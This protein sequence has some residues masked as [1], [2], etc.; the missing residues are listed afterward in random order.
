MENRKQLKWGGWSGTLA[1]D[2]SLSGF[3][4]EHIFGIAWIALTLLSLAVR[5]RGFP[6]ESSDYQ[7]FLLPWFQELKKSGGFAALGR[8]VGNYN[9][10]YLTI[11]AALTYLPVPPLFSIKAVSILFDYVGA[12]AGA[13]IVYSL[14]SNKKKGEL[15]AAAAWLCILFHP[16]VFINSAFWG[17]C[18]FIYV[19]FLLLCIKELIR[20]SYVPA[21]VW[22]SFALAFKLQAVFFLPVLLIL[23]F[24]NRSHSVVH[25]LI[26]PLG[27]SVLSIPALV[28]G[29][30][31]TD[32]FK[33]YLE[34]TQFKQLVSH[35]PGLYYLLMGTYSQYAV[36][37]ICLCVA[38][39]G[40]G[41]VLWISYQKPVREENILLLG[42]WASSVCTY[43]LPSMHER[44]SFLTVVLSVL[45]MLS[46]RKDRLP[47]VL[48][49]AG[50]SFTTMLTCVNAVNMANKI[51]VDYIA[52][53]AV[54]LVLVAAVTWLM[55]RRATE[56]TS[57]D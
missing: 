6:T 38:F 33:I 47:A 46:V 56:N 42:M 5:W 49:A 7:H 28:A 12:A 19:S 54:D 20:E 39:L 18:D 53:S 41:A 8:P 36:V 26:I 51:P 37:G 27:V 9:F 4:R 48:I 22:F 57:S 13:R 11:L 16:V 10:P 23:Y 25:Y 34:Q 45:Y 14:A 15:L 52:L 32:I 40:A 31:V 24:T 29:R 21:F 17:Q 1:F 44:Y 30:P 43:F 50:W 55:I 2:R 3:V 35:F